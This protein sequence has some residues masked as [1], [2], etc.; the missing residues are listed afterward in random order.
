[1]RSAAITNRDALVA[2]GR[3]LECL[4]I[5]WNSLEAAVALLSGFVAGSVSLVGFG[6]DSAI[7]TA[8][9]L[10]LL[11]RLSVDGAAERRERA[12]HRAHQILLTVSPFPA[13]GCAIFAILLATLNRV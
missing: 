9:A 6:L 4:T 11:W 5:G 1:M 12:E 3:R 2:R 7:E 10:V 13:H 8:S